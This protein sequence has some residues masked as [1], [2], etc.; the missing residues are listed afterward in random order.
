MSLPDF[1]PVVEEVG[2]YPYQVLAA[3]VWGGHRGDHICIFWEGRGVRI[4]D[5]RL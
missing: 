1:T 4:P 3:A 5:D 2:L